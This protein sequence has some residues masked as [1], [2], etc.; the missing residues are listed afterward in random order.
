M[1]VRHQLDIYPHTSI[2]VIYKL[3]QKPLES[4][5]AVMPEFLIDLCQCGCDFGI[6]GVTPTQ[7]TPLTLWELHYSHVPCP[8]WEHHYVKIC[9]SNVLSMTLPYG[10]IFGSVS[11]LS[12]EKSSKN[13]QAYYI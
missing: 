13:I 7:L 12:L 6:V 10:T 3:F 4:S 11:A 2:V 5:N 8:R 1:G 9:L